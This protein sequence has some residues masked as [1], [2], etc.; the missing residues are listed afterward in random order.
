MTTLFEKVR[1]RLDMM[2]PFPET[3][4][5]IEIE[6]LKK[7]FS[8]SDAELFLEMTPMLQSPEDVSEK[9]GKDVNELRE[10]L[11]DM[12]KRGLLFRHRKGDLY[13]YAA[14]PFIVGIF[15]HQVNRM[16]KSFAQLSKTY[17][18]TSLGKQ[19]QS[20]KT[21][22]LRTI[23]INKTISPELPVAPYDDVINIIEENDKIAIAPCICRRWSKMTGNNCEKPEEVCFTF[24]S[25]GQYYVDNG[26]A[27][28]ITK[29][30]AFEILKKGEEAGLVMQPFNTKGK[31]GGMC[32][33]C[34]DC[35]GVLRSVKMQPKPA[36][37]VKSNYYA[38]VNQDECSGCETC[39]DRCQVEAVTISDSLA[40]IDLDRC[41]GCGLCVTTCPTDAITLQKK[42]N[43]QLYAPP[44]SGAETYMKIAQERG[45]I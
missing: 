20:Y 28:F 4:S 23:P 39:I 1:E 34:G 25:H 30:E 29:E 8:E 31:I 32:S 43:D 36:D 18:E 21:P 14:V 3:E 19:I 13:R 27:R 7:L 42:S 35:C 10:K 24:G 12:A 16:D 33:C 26:M 45:K 17:Y 15:E 9:T 38:E 44:A 5:G 37:F 6:V 22:I 11:E 40:N 2:A 41:I